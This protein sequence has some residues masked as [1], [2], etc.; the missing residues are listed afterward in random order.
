MYR[1]CAVVAVR[2][3]YAHALFGDPP[4]VGCRFALVRSS[5]ARALARF[6]RDGG[7]W[8]LY[9]VFVAFDSCALW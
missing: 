3:F 2:F 4:L 7:A 1:S 8:F 6:V 5:Y 9:L